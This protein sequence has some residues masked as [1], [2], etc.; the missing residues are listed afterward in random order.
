MLIF[1]TRSKVL[2]GPA[3]QG[4]S[5]PNCGQN[6]YNSFGAVRYFHIFWI[7]VFPFSKKVGVECTNCK[8]AVMDKEV[9]GP[10]PDAVRSEIFTRNRVLPLFVGSLLIAGIAVFGAYS[11]KQESA[12]EL[13]YLENP[14]A[15]D[16]YVMDFSHVFEDVDVNYKYGV[17]RVE[18]VDA[19]T[20]EVSVSNYGYDRA[21]IPLAD[22]RRDMAGDEFF[23]AETMSMAR[24][25][26]VE[27][28]QSNVIR[29]VRR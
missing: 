28:K 11:A 5:C 14:V 10:F 1:G 6:G 2:D 16:L 24:E 15:S 4:H 7:P 21:S 9:S 8:H 19:E 17:M 12:R 20:I 25:Y 22:L 3:F 13:A 27:L 26:L 18:T 29:D 23:A